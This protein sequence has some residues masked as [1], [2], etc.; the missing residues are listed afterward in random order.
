L[1]PAN[2]AGTV[3]HDFYPVAGGQYTFRVQGCPV[4]VPPG[5]AIC[6]PPSDVVAVAAAANQTSL[7]TFLEM[8]G[9]DPSSPGL[10]SY[11]I[12]SLRGLL[13]GI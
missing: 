6:S 13:N 4:T 5:D 9:I 3:E 7:R 8:N 10:R 1:D 11:G 12:P 2:A